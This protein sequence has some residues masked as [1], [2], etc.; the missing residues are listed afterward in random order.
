MDA[1]EIIDRLGGTG[2][3]AELAGCK[4]PSVS[5]WR[6]TN[7]IPRDKLMR[8]AAQIESAGIATRRQLF[9]D[10]WKVIWPEL[11][12]RKTKVAA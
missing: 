6:T 10:D 11:A 7:R 8:L 3:V 12:K 1:S 2:V 9:P 4:S 5:E